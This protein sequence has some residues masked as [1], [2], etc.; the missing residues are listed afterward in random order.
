MLMI[1][2]KLANKYSLFRFPEIQNPPE[3]VVGTLANDFSCFKQ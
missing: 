2:N 1:A 3:I